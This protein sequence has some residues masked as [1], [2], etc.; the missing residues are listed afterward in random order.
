MD[1]YISTVINK[2]TE[3]EQNNSFQHNKQNLKGIAAGAAIALGYPAPNYLINPKLLKSIKTDD[4][5]NIS[6]QQVDNVLIAMTKKFKLDEKGFKALYFPVDSEEGKFLTKNCGGMAFFFSSKQ[7]IN[8]AESVVNKL[9]WLIHETGHAVNGNCTKL[10]KFYYNNIARHMPTAKF[11]GVP[12][13]IGLGLSHNKNKEDKG[14]NKFTKFFEKHIGVLATLPFIPGLIDEATA[15]L[16][17]LKFIK[18]L[19]PSIYKAARRNFGIGFMT[20]ATE[21]A[22]AVGGA[23]LAIYLKDKIASKP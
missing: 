15:S 13:L 3:P 11:L 6:K 21:A 4:A 16:R 7:G 14:Y 17:G 23:K 1:N 22:L 19:E 9:Y 20:Y 10:G 5:L 8:Q 12:I 18:K 2:R